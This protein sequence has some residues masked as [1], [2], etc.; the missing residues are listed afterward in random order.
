MIT[1]INSTN[2]HKNLTQLFSKEMVNQLKEL[3]QAVDY[4]TL[5]DLPKDFAFTELYGN[6]T[7]K[8]E[9]IFT[10]KLSQSNKLIFFV[11]EYNGSYAGILKMFLEAFHP[12][13]WHNKKAMVVGTASGRAGNVV[14]IDQL[15]TVLNYLQIN[16]M[17]QRLVISKIEDLITNGEIADIITKN[18]I[19]QFAEKFIN[20]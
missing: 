13:I 2:R 19:K 11:P 18:N 15:V 9:K 10:E 3:N 20:F 5:E 6:R 14:G 17:P 12:K 1:V 8:F 16:V 7:P 4:Y